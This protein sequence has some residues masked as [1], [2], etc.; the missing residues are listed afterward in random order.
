MQNPLLLKLRSQRDEWQT[1]LDQIVK[2]AAEEGRQE[3][4]EEETKDVNTVRESLGPLDERIKQLSAD[5]ASR[6]SYLETARKLDRQRDGLPPEVQHSTHETPRR[7]WGEQFTESGVLEEYLRGGGVGKSRAIDVPGSLMREVTPSNVITTAS[8]GDFQ[9]AMTL[10]D[11]IAPFEPPTVLSLIRR[12]VTTASAIQYIQEES[13]TNNAA[14]VA[15][16]AVKPQSA[17]T[18]T[19]MTVVVETKAHWIAITRQALDDVPMMRSYV[20]GRLRFGLIQKISDEVLNGET[21]PATPGLLTGAQTVSGA[22]LYEAVLQAV[23]AVQQA[24]YQATGVVCNGVD[25]YNLINSLRTT[26]GGANTSLVTDSFPYRILGLPL[27]VT[28][29]IPAGTALVGDFNTGAQLWDRQQTQVLISDSHADFFVRNQLVL[30]AEWRGAL[31]IYAPEAFAKATI[32]SVTPEPAST[33]SS[34]STTSSK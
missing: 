9:S 34:R 31:A 2:R 13:F 23:A 20:D 7:S 25:F 22:D 4:T 26:L 11:I 10:P 17:L 30:L 3:L 19:S 21:S 6:L 5:E 29:G 16:G 32:A 24:G 1:Q 18:F 15:E 33:T 14:R 8:L 28:P 27:L 12:G